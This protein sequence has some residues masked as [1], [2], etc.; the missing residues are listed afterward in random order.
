MSRA[1]PPPT[2]FTD[3]EKIN[4]F[5]LLINLHDHT[6]DHAPDP[7]PDG[8]LA[9]LALAAA[10]VAWWSRWQ[11]I[12]IHAALRAGA[13]VTDVAAATGLDTGE[14][15]R[16]WTRWADVQT[17]LVIAGRPSVNPDEVRT[18]QQRIREEVH[19]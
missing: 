9:E 19:P 13:T 11:P 8:V 4:P 18:I 10:V 15:V 1:L 2:R 5:Q 14:V 12:T 3:A 16:R 6:L 17:K 7:T